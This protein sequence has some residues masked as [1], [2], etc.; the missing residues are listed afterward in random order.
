MTPRIKQSLKKLS[1]LLAGLAVIVVASG[2]GGGNTGPSDPSTP[3]PTPAIQT[4][5]IV[6]T[7]YAGGVKLAP[8]S[9]QDNGI[10][11]YDFP[12]NQ[13]GQISTSLTGASGCSFTGRISEDN[14]WG[15]A[16][17]GWGGSSSDSMSWIAGKYQSGQVFT[18][19]ADLTGTCSG[20]PVA[21]KTVLVLKMI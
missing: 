21:L 10:S 15:P 9:I 1:V 7:V 16:G 13:P 5:T 17:H 20:T 11:F 4:P 14:P 19:T 18:V 6:Q 3:T 2:C 12:A 8:T